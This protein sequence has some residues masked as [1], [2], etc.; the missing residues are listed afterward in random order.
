MAE[1]AFRGSIGSGKGSGI[2]REDRGRSLLTF[3]ANYTVIDIE[4]TGLDPWQD[5]LLELAALKV[6]DHQEA[7]RFEILI[8]PF[9]RIS[10]EVVEITGITNELVADAPK[11][12]DV[13]EDFLAFIGDDIL[14]GHN[15]NF[16]IS[17]L[18]EK[19]YSLTSSGITNDSIDTM[20]HAKRLL[21]ELEQYRLENLCQ[22]LEIVNPGAHRAMNDVLTT[23]HVFEAMRKL[24]GSGSEADEP[25]QMSLF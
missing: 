18:Y 5:E 7:E 13:R 4:T 9:K 10:D 12:A 23:F 16:D 1:A 15:V 22:K 21:P 20:R 3:P 2:V 25:K 17:F 8:N 11:F 19:C 14:V 6:R 24:D